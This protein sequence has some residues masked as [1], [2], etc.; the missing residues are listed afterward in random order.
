MKNYLEE[1]FGIN[2]SL[3]E[4]KV[5]MPFYLKNKKEYWIMQSEIFE[6]IFLKIQ[7]DEFKVLAFQKYLEQLNNYTD[8]EIVLWFDKITSYQRQTLIKNKIPFV[9]LNS[10]LYIPTLGMCFKE[11]FSNV[12]APREK[13]TAI[14]QAVILYFI[15]YAKKEESYLQADVASKLNLSAM[16]MSRA[17]QELK[18]LELINVKKSGRSK[19]ISPVANGKELYLLAKKY[20]QSPV[21]NRM[22]V[23]KVSDEENL[24]FAGESALAKKTMLNP[25][26]TCE[27]ALYKK[28][29]GNIPKENIVDPKWQMNKDYIELEV[30]KYDPALFAVNGI[31]DMISLALSMEDTNDERV[32]QQ[33]E[34]MWEEYEW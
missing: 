28:Q 13:L 23:V 1:L 15:Y 25:P 8:L 3:C 12:I 19:V 18:E 9:V 11:Q 20:M 26:N 17:V 29:L 27:K 33:I 24:P 2:V 21:Q 14:A 32:E 5:S 4:W 34:E 30:W 16:D 31:V 7:M 10:Q 6:C 22:Y